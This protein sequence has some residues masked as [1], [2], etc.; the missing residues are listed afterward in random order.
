MQPKNLIKYM[1]LQAS[2]SF[3]GFAIALAWPETFCK[4]SGSWYD[5]ITGLFGISQNH[6]YKVGHAALVLVDGMGKCN[7]FDFG[8]YHA[9]YN[10]G[11]V[12][13]EVTDH[14]LEIR[15]G[16]SISYDGKRIENLEDILTGLQYNAECHGEG[17]IHA[18]YCQ[19]NFEL[20][21]K[22]A[23]Q[24]Q[25]QSPIP[26]G[27]FLPNG[28]NC[29]RF[30]NACIYAGMPD[31]KYRLKLKF[32]VPLTPTPL[33]NVN[34]LS[35]KLIIP[36]LRQYEPFCPMPV[37]DMQKLKTT[38][39]EPARPSNISGKAKWL[40]GEGAGSWF[41]IE[42]PKEGYDNRYLVKRF[43]PEGNLECERLFSVIN[44]NTLELN[45]PY[46][47]EHIS[48]CARVHIRQS[49]TSIELG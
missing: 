22:K 49:G 15:T 20:A 11:R 48:H 26:Y 3:S 24:L 41:I 9:P 32:C 45:K 42:E 40:S 5:R 36:K 35:N 39:P 1:A 47:V 10:H 16:A 2:N 44:N 8:R 21:L 17:A 23:L 18:S 37:A 31:L 30:V 38:L 27:P 33:N 12:R 28:T 43:D 19:V 13:S 6:Y 4:L 7:Y 34:A 29:S 25:D 14:G 46:R